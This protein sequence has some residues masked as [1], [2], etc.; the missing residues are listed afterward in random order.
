MGHEVVDIAEEQKQKKEAIENIADELT[1]KL[2]AA[3]SCLLNTK[4]QLEKKNGATL[5]VLKER[6]TSDKNI[7]QND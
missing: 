7:Q 4:E 2:T 5:A 3:Q 1:S 6:K